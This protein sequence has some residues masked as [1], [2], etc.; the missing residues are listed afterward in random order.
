MP[1]RGIVPEELRM[2]QDKISNKAVKA[3]KKHSKYLAIKGES[4]FIMLIIITAGF[5]IS[6]TGF[7]VFTKAALRESISEDVYTID[8]E[9]A[10]P[11][12]QDLCESKRKVLQALYSIHPEWE[13]SGYDR[14]AP[15]YV[16]YLRDYIIKPEAAIDNI[17][18][19]KAAD[20][21]LKLENII[22]FEKRSDIGRMSLDGKRIAVRLL[23]EAYEFCGLIPSFGADHRIEAIRDM[24]GNIIYNAAPATGK[25]RIHIAR[26]AI[27]CIALPVLL[28]P[29]LSMAKR[30]RLFIKEVITDGF[31]K[32]KYA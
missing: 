25:S 9:A 17:N 14:E 24:S 5:F 29:C 30:N 20:R 10:L 12:A 16:R 21:L 22:S 8:M 1:D 13:S 32:K 11:S 3:E 27:I 23:E 4:S 2:S 15:E 7:T 28:L 26:I 31:D 18:A 6:I 19:D